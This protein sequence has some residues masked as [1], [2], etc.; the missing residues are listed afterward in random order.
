MLFSTRIK[1]L[2]GQLA[3]LE[4]SVATLTTANAE[5]TAANLQCAERFNADQALILSITQERDGIVIER[6]TAVSDRDRIQVELTSER[7]S[8][9]A[10]IRTTVD[11][12]L[13]DAGSVPIQRDPTATAKT[14]P[15]AEGNGLRGLKRATAYLAERQPQTPPAPANH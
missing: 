2:E 15:K 7:E 9:E 11:Q 13:A 8:R 10:T 3:V 4:G 12:R 6:D 5:L 14:E 1:E